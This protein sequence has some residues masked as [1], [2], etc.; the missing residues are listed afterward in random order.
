MKHDT[1]IIIESAAKLRTG[2]TDVYIQSI[3]RQ[4]ERNQ[5]WQNDITRQ[6]ARNEAS[7]DGCNQKL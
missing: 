2:I 3:E 7:R 4:I 1:D 6:L 5:E